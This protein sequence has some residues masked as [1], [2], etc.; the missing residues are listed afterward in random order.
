MV[1]A[2]GDGGVQAIDLSWSSWG[3]G[4][5]RATGFISENDCNGGCANGTF[6]NY[7]ALF[8]LNSLEHVG[9]LNRFVRLTVTYTGA[10]PAGSP[11]GDQ[12]HTYFLGT[13]DGQPFPSGNS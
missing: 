1:I 2:C 11:W 9:T 5:A 6:H 10:R 13:Y 8:A 4:T 7:S 3:P 12:S